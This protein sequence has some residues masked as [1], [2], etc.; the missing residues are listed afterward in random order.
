MPAGPVEGAGDGA[1]AEAVVSDVLSP[2]QQEQIASAD[3]FFIGSLSPEHGADAN[4]RGGMPGFVTVEGPGALSWPDYFGNSFYMTLGNLE[5]NP[6]CGLAF[7]VW[8]TGGLLLLTG[9]ARI[10]WDPDRAAASPGALRIVR[11]AVERAVQVEQ[12]NPLRWELMGYSRFNP[13]PT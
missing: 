10:D 6:R 2:A 5:L 3:T 11:F 13:P 12:A 4:H 1:S 7:P 9:S 8:E